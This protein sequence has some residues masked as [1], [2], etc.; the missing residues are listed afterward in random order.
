MIT[1]LIV[2]SHNLID[3]ICKDGN[4]RK[5]LQCRVCGLLSAPSPK[6]YNA[7]PLPSGTGNPQAWVI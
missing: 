5:M 4:R 1:G 2:Q 6:P 3:Y 7:R